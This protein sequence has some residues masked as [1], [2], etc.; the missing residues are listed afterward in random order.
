MTI[1]WIDMMPVVRAVCTVSG[2][3]SFSASG[4]GARPTPL[5]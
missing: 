3:I 2:D 4:R 1:P 5:S